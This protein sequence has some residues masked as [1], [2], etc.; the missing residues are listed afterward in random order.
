MQSGES[1]CLHA[2]FMWH[3]GNLCLAKVWRCGIIQGFPNY[4]TV[5]WCY[6]TFPAK[7]VAPSTKTSYLSSVPLMFKA[8]HI[9]YPVRYARIIVFTL[10]MRVPRLRDRKWEAGGESQ[11]RRDFLIHSSASLASML[12]PTETVDAGLPESKRHPL[13][14]SV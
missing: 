9:H 8:F 11:A 4:P 2:L 12:Y 6:V 5:Y 3:P 1:Y 13:H 7:T 14:S 10:Q